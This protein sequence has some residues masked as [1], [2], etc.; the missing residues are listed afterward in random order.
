M[1]LD[2]RRNVNSIDYQLSTPAAYHY[3]DV[4]DARACGAE[5]VM[6]GEL[7]TLPLIHLQ[8]HRPALQ[9]TSRRSAETVH[10]SLVKP[11]F[12]NVLETKM[13]PQ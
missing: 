13:I 2:S 5:M 1:V 6:E 4:L 8:L 3:S 10:H 12:R 11:S 7:H 9:R